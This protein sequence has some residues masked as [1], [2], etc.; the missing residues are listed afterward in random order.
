TLQP[1]AGELASAVGAEP[2]VGPELLISLPPA[3]SP[4]AA[5]SFAPVATPDAPLTTG[6]ALTR[7]TRVRVLA[8]QFEGLSGEV[9][10]AGELPFRLSSEV[11]AEVAEVQRADGVRLR[12]PLAHLQIIGD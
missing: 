6:L 9:V 12:I 4:P 11:T 5:P 7:G 2:G 1:L 8:G 3:A 10:A